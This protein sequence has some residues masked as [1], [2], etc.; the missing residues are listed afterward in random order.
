VLLPEVNRTEAAE[1]VDRVR[2]LLNEHN[3][4]PKGPVFD[5]SIGIA[6][7]N[8]SGLDAGRHSGKDGASAPASLNEALHLADERMYQDKKRHKRV[9][10]HS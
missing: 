10:E 2:C 5:I 9:N 8:A 6:T 1:V 7:R 3:Q 4:A